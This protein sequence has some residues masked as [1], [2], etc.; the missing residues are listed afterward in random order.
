MTANTNTQ[1][2]V[3]DPLRAACTRGYWDSEMEV[4]G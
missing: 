4:D 1:T 3:L 2:T